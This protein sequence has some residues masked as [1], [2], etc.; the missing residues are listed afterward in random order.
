MPKS[1][2]HLHNLG[3]LLKMRES[4]T[5]LEPVVAALIYLQRREKEWLNGKGILG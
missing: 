2:G 3:T 5:L 1:S 4:R